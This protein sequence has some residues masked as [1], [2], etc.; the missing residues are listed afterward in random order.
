MPPMTETPRTTGNPTPPRQD[1]LAE[2]LIAG[3]M[4]L[5][6]F[7]GLSQERLYEIATLG[8]RLLTQGQPQQAI[9]LFTGLV[10]ASP[11]DSVFHCNLASAYVQVERYSD[12]ME[13]YTQA[14][15]LNIANVDALALRS[16]LFLREGKVAEALSDIQAALRLDPQASR[17]TTQRARTVLTLLNK[18]AETVEAAETQKR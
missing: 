6:Q 9:V 13:E 14:L 3:D 15:H 5:A 4:T 2:R 12:A 8:H 16:E 10:A 18:M 17:E 11:Y 7:L 1:E